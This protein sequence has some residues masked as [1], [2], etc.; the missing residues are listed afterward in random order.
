MPGSDLVIQVERAHAQRIARWNEKDL[1]VGIRPQ[2]LHLGG[3]P[4]MPALEAQVAINEY[5]GERS[6]LTLTSGERSFRAVVD[7]DTA[8][9]RGE[10]VRVHYALEDVMVFSGKTELIIL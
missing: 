10:R 4:A 5:L 8:A 1:K 3:D 7:P 9:A 2:S 6:I